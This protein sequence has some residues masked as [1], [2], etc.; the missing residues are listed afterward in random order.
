MAVRLLVY[1]GLLYQDLI[2]SKQLPASGMLPPVIPI[3]LYNGRRPWTAAQ[4]LGA[5]V[6]EGP[7]GLRA[8]CPHLTYL[9][10]EE[11]RYSEALLPSH[12]NLAAALFRL[13]NS[14]EPADVQRALAGLITW[15]QSPE[16]AELR[17][18][19]TVWLT[20]VLLPARGP[21]VAIPNMHDCTEGTPC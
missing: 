19:F 9:L 16:D 13:E 15:L 12:P 6:Q 17:R 5:L 3:V 10:L 21:G 1:V 20:R 4:E 18:A 8:Y 14:R 11:Q 7:G 2:R